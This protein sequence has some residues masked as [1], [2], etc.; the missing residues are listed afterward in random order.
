MSV[1]RSLLRN[2]AFYD[3]TNPD[4]PLG[5]LFQNGS[6]TE[7]NFLDM[8]GILLVEASPLRV[9]ERSIPRSISQTICDE[10]DRLHQEVRNR[11]RKCVIS[12][13]VNLELNIRAN[14]WSGFKVAHVFPP[15]HGVLEIRNNHGRYIAGINDSPLFAE[16][17]SSQNGILLDATIHQK[18]D[19]Y[20]IS[21]NPD[22]KYKIVVFEPDNRGIDGRILAT[23]CRNPADPRRVSDELLRWH[24]HQSV[25]AN[26]RGAG[27]PIFEHDFLPGTD[28]VG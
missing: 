18:F 27:E 9:Q 1:D 2:V 10:E 28:T 7:A 23:V 22:D 11:D 24:F 15:E 8:L 20:L 14:N 16:V 12:G 13:N 6:I 5:G 4:L 17:Y 25:L 3:V 21:V 19:Q 26:L